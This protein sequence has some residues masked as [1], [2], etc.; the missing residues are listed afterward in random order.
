LKEFEISLQQSGLVGVVLRRRERDS[1]LGRFD[2]FGKPPRLR[3]GGSE[4]A[5]E[6]WDAAV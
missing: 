4:D 5:K 3:V 6:P 2:G 1:T